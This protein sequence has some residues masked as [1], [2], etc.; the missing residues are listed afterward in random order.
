MKT[1]LKIKSKSLAAE[2]RIIR[3]EEQ[4]WPGDSAVRRSIH[5]HRVHVVRSEAR[6]THLAYCY[7][8]C[9][10]YRQVEPKCRE[11]NRPNWDRVAVLVAKYGG[12]D[13]RDASQKLAEWSS[14][15][16]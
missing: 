3:R 14:A 2:A 12:M 15:E 6:S 10:K 8:R 1:H 7:L 9:R 4:R 16:E 5:E 11:N 13:K